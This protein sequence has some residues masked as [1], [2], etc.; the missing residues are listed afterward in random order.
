MVFVISCKV[1]SYHV[2]HIPLKISSI[3]RNGVVM[4]YLYTSMLN[5]YP[6]ARVSKTMCIIVQVAY[7]L[8]DI[9]AFSYVLLIWHWRCVEDN[10]MYLPTSFI[11][12]HISTP[13][14]QGMF[15]ELWMCWQYKWNW[16]SVLKE[17]GLPLTLRT[18][19][20]T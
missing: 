9:F 3:K 10:D 8:L 15:N 13:C 20:E 16:Q 18:H 4:L 2:M 14:F 1:D 19:M 17:L 12:S 11:V 5:Y 6:T 7:V